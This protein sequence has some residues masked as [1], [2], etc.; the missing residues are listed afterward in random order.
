VAQNEC[1]PFDDK[2]IRKLEVV[3]SRG[4]PVAEIEKTVDANGT[5][6]SLGQVQLELLFT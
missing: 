1:P 2:V 3:E 6:L 5:V 4:K